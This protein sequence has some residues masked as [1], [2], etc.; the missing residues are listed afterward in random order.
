MRITLFL[1]ASLVSLLV[2][3][4]T[5]RAEPFLTGIADVPL[6]PDYI[7][8]AAD[9]MVFDTVN[10]RVITVEAYG[11]RR[12]TEEIQS[13]YLQ[14]MPSLGWYNRAPGTGQNILTF[15]RDGENLSVHHDPAAERHVLKFYLQPNAEQKP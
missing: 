12:T 8:Q 1:F 10:G 9:I 5:V 13:F 15:D 2:G 6:P 11:P 7:E 4:T 14:T 3:S